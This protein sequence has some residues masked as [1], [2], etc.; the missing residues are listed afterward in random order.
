MAGQRRLSL[1]GTAVAVSDRPCG[2]RCGWSRQA[3]DPRGFSCLS[4]SVGRYVA[5]DRSACGV[6]SLSLRVAA[7]AAKRRRKKRTPARLLSTKHGGQWD[8]E[9]KHHH[10]ALYLRGAANEF[11]DRDWEGTAA[12]AARERGAARKAVD[13]RGRQSAA[14][15]NLARRSG[16]GSSV[17]C[18]QAARSK[19]SEKER[20]NSDFLRYQLSRAERS[21]CWR[22]EGPSDEKGPR[23]TRDFDV[24][25]PSASE[26]WNARLGLLADLRA[27]CGLLDDH[28]RPGRPGASTRST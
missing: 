28:P 26:R 24:T 21:R 25:V 9:R 15:G 19:K 12:E 1:A 22:G 16:D 5:A 14:G 10:K 13:S 20:N 23:L 17:G 6:D 27:L 11:A 4:T 7:R 3:R 2:F 8:H 18:F